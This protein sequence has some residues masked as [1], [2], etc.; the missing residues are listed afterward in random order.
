M[1]YFEVW[2]TRWRLLA[3]LRSPRSGVLGAL[4]V[5]SVLN[6]ISIS[7]EELRTVLHREV[8]VQVRGCCPR[9]PQLCPTNRLLSRAPQRDTD[10]ST[11]TYSG[12]IVS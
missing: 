3:F 4:G 8:F 9:L 5:F 11:Y 7:G 2:K 6:F 12:F 1:K 10:P